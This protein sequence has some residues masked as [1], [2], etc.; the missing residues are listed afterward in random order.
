MVPA[1]LGNS[2]NI[3]VG[4]WVVAI[5]SPFGLD[6][7]VTAGIISAKGRAD[8]GIAAYE[9]FIQ[10]DAAINP[11]NSGGPLVNLKGQ[12]VG[13]NTA[14]ASRNGGYMGVGFSIPINMARTVKDSIIKHGRVDRGMLGAGIQ[15]LDDKLAESFG[16]QGTEGVLVSQVFPDSPADKAGLQTG[17][18]IVRLNGKPTHD[19]NQLRYMVAATAPGTNATMTVFREGKRIRLPVTIGLRDSHTFA[20]KLRE[21]DSASGLGMTAQTLTSEL[22]RRLGYEKNVSGVV[23]TQVESGSL[24]DR[25]EIR[26]GDVIVSVDDRQVASVEDFRTATDRADLERG[27]RLRILR[28]GFSQYVVIKSRR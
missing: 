22:A 4:Q 9:D 26:A 2:D 14:I 23:V 13:V 5:G 21:S 15:D 7:T 12:V 19:R 24:A 20:Q 8:V 1:Q 25:A 11:G 18:I 27:M 17:D 3:E 10:T 6:Q 16:F 28:G